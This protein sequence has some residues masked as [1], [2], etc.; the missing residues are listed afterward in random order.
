MTEIEKSLGRLAE[1][2]NA[3]H[4]ACETAVNSALTHAMNAGQMLSEAK[5][6]VPH[7]SWSAWLT[8]N[9]EGSERTAQAYMRLHRRRDEI[10]NGA[11]DL[12]LRGALQELSEPKRGAVEERPAPSLA[13][14]EARA[15]AALTKFEEGTEEAAEA[16]R[17]WEGVAREHGISERAFSGK[18]EE[19]VGWMREAA[20]TLLAL[21]DEVPWEGGVFDQS[22]AELEHHVRP[23]DLPPS[24][25]RHALEGMLSYR[26][27]HQTIGELYRSGVLSR[28]DLDGE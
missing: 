3:E 1:R 21:S 13:E 26:Q 4:L 16:L 6:G 18:R 5:E 25:E 19:A 28:P 11:A 10:R 9:F 23:V 24:R 20:I 15:E 14:L 27:M 12:S 7:G 8:E 22:V 17:E 2:I